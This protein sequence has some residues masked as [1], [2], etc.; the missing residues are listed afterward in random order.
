MIRFFRQARKELVENNR[1][2]RYAAHALGEVVLVVLGILIA[3]QINNANENRLQHQRETRYLENLKADL[4]LTVRELDRYIEA[5]NGR[6]E[7][8]VRILD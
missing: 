3:L 6:I 4:G 5:R 2:R 1:L 7:S 8:G